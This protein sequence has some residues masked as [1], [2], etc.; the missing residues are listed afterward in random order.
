MIRNAFRIAMG[1]LL[2]NVLVQT[3]SVLG[4]FGSHTF[5]AF[6]YGLVGILL[7]STYQFILAVLAG[8]GVVK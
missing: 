7:I 6:Y 3:L 2:V 4:M 8:A 5:V 1:T